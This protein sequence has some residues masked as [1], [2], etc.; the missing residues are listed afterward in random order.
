MLAVVLL[1][2]EESDIVDRVPGTGGFIGSACNCTRTRA[3]KNGLTITG[4]R[5]P[6]MRSVERMGHA[7]AEGRG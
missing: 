3:R 7:P 2:N 4:A 1:Y 5:P 6:V